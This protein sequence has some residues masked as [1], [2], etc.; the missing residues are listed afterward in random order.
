MGDPF[1]EVESQKNFY[2]KIWAGI[3]WPTDMSPAFAC[4]IGQKYIQETKSQKEA[5]KE[6]LFFLAECQS[7]ELSLEHFFHLVTDE[8]VRL[9]AD[10]IY[11]NLGREWSEEH[12][13]E[14]EGKFSGYV[15]S[16][17][18]F[19]SDNEIPYVTLEAAPYVDN[20]L[21]TV[22]IINDLKSKH[23]LNIPED[24]AVFEQLSRIKKSDLQN[25]PEIYF[26]A[27]EALR[28]VVGAYAKYRPGPSLSGFVP[29]RQ[30]RVIQAKFGGEHG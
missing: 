23:R 28:H 15:T 9:C 4:F 14:G 13:Q 25:Y 30:K 16:F 10:K 27:I 24:C 21:Y 6:P 11:A 20:Y 12:E 1:G 19:L 17:R 7:D 26:Y 3:A 29:D 5:A 22:Q 2:R 8:S 18:R